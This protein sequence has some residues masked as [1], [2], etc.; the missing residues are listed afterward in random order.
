[1]GK[2]VNLYCILGF[3]GEFCFILMLNDILLLKTETMLCGW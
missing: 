3:W 1:M 2:K